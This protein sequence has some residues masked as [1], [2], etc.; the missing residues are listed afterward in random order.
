MV[1]MLVKFNRCSYAQLWFAPDMG[2]PS[3]AWA[4]RIESSDGDEATC[5]ALM[6]GLKICMGFEIIDKSKIEKWKQ[7]G[8]SNSN[9]SKYILD[10]SAIE[11]A[12][13]DETW[14][15]KPSDTLDEEL[16]I[17]EQELLSRE[18]AKSAEDGSAF[19]PE[20]LSQRMR[21]FVDT[22]A[23]L[24]GATI[25]DEEI[26]FNEREFFRELNQIGIMVDPQDACTSEDEGSSFYSN[27]SYSGS[28]SAQLSKSTSSTP[29]STNDGVGKE[30]ASLSINQDKRKHHGT[31]GVDTGYDGLDTETDSDDAFYENYDEVLAQ[32]LRG[33]S[34]DASFST[35]KD[36]MEDSSSNKKQ[37]I[38]GA[39][40]EKFESAEDRP[41]DLNFNLVSSL[42]SSYEEQ[43]GQAGPASTLAALLGIALPTSRDTQ[44]DGDDGA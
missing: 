19:D 29:R 1:P 9:L 3:E 8:D 43:A 34:L 7:H 23:T 42:L 10:L 28:S 39:G 37:E 11:T 40:D 26:R 21:Q 17:R 2:P 12:G 36:F 5:K 35:K 18:E 20:E 44:R 14:L 13:D 25:Q 30:H 41:I 24:E 6:L 31:Y 38:N 33:T 27:G 16:R 32:Q 22:M 4:T 15:Y